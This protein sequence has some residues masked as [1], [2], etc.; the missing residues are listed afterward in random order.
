[1]DADCIVVARGVICDGYNC[2]C[3]GRGTINVDGQARYEAAIASLTRGSGPYC[4]CPYLG[5]ARCVQSQ[6]VF[7]NASFRGLPNPP[8]CGDGG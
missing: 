8:G 3:P 7:C 1:M 5:Y 2:L 4:S 6:C